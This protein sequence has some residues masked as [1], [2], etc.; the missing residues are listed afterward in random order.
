MHPFLHI[1][2]Q[3]RAVLVENKREGRQ[4]QGKER[5]EERLET[6]EHGR[7]RRAEGCERQEQGRRRK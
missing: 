1:P 7:E 5:E 4:K 3:D 2:Q 6:Q